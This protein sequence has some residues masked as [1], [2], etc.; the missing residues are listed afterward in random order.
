MFTPLDLNYTHNT[1]AAT[2]Q[3]FDTP[4]RQATHYGTYSM[5][6]IVSSVWNDLERNTI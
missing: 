1:R 4:Q 2:N 3:L 6:S 5:T